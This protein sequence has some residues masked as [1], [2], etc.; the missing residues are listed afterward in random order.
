MRWCCIKTRPYT[1]KVDLTED[2]PAGLGGLG[3]LNRPAAALFLGAGAIA[4]FAWLLSHLRSRWNGADFNLYYAWAVALRTGLNPYV[5]DLRPLEGRL[6][7]TTN[8]LFHSANYPPTFL[9]LFEP[10]TY[11]QPIVA[12]WLWITLNL[13]ALAAILIILLR[14]EPSFTNWTKLSLGSL[15]LL[16]YPIYN[17]FDY[18]QT[19]LLILLL[20]LVVLRSSQLRYNFEG[21]VALALASLLKIFP[22]AILGYLVLLRRWRTIAY[23]IL[24]LTIGIAL[25]VALVGRYNALAFRAQIGTLNGERGPMSVSGFVYHV[26]RMTFSQRASY[27]LL[28]RIVTVLSEVA[29]L[30]LTIRGTVKASSGPVGAELS[31]GLWLIALVLLSP[32]A[33]AHYGVLFLPSFVQL[34][35]AADRRVAPTLAI[36][37]AVAAYAIAEVVGL[38]D[39]VGTTPIHKLLFLSA[40]LCFA[41]AY[42]LCTRSTEVAEFAVP[43]RASRPIL[44]ENLL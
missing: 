1:K 27:K 4:Y 17:L 14:H 11:L 29:I 42:M 8:Q 43:P 9:L 31:F 20:L 13:L 19:Q 12:Y 38:I 34:A 6:G 16:Y 15:A 7:L 30:G 39:P 32:T 41:F 25:T 40:I 35:S 44:Q 21:G 5:T 33:W 24:S 22:L 2:S 18:A 28:E 23:A 3:L 10:L 36:W 37:S 26:F